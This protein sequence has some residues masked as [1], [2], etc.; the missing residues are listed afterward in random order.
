[1]VGLVAKKKKKIDH[2]WVKTAWSKEWEY[3][4]EGSSWSA[5][6]EYAKELNTRAGGV[7]DINTPKR[8]FYIHVQHEFDKEVRKFKITKSVHT[9]LV[10]L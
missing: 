6:T 8:N 1:M 9:S 4:E 5:A 10:N 7:D 2:Y 3:S